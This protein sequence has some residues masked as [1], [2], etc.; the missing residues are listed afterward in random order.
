MNGIISK[1]IPAEA[2]KKEK[3]LTE[4]DMERLI[5]THGNHLLRL[6]ILYLK[7]TALAEDALQ[8]T[9]IRAWEKYSSFQGKSSERTWLTTIAVNVCRNYLRSPWNRR[10][11]RRELSDL[12]GQGSN[13]FE[14]I[15][16]RIDVMNAIL[17]LK[18]KYRIV[19][20]L[21]YYEELSVKEIGAV[22]SCKESTVLTRLKRAREQLSGL[23]GPKKEAEQNE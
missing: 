8:D 15:E 3:C 12:I 9:Y 21:H 17:K 1:P 18:E 14:H 7:D 2:G 13:E 19:V 22:L 6:C 11:D 16:H 23:L 5:D 10:T 4:I 20:L